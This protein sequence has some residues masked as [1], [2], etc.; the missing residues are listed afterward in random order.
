[1]CN[2]IPGVTF[3]K[4]YGRLQDAL[5]HRDSCLMKQEW[6]DRHLWRIF[7]YEVFL[8]SSMVTKGLICTAVV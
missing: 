6:S 2:Y 5:A 7:A 8:I 3:Y 4:T 1:M